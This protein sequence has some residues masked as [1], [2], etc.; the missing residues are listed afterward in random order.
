MLILD[1]F[2][3]SLIF[4]NISLKIQ[5]GANYKSQREYAL[6]GSLDSFLALATPVGLQLTAVR[7]PVVVPFRFPAVLEAGV[8]I[9]QV[10]RLLIA[11]DA[12]TY[13]YE[14]ALGTVSVLDWTSGVT[15]ATQPVNAKTVQLLWRLF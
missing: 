12:R 9:R 10:K 6:S 8:S 3:L 4:G 7:L 14:R 13:F 15:I 1:R 5:L 11:F 2:F